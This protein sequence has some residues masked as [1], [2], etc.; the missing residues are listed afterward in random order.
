MRNSRSS[1]GTW[2]SSDPLNVGVSGTVRMPHLHAGQTQVV[3][4]RN[5]ED[6]KLNNKKGTTPSL[7]PSLV[8]SRDIPAQPL[9]D[10]LSPEIQNINTHTF[11]GSGSA[12]HVRK[13]TPS[14]SPRVMAATQGRQPRPARRQVL[15]V[16]AQDG[17][18]TVSVAEGHHLGL[19][20][21]TLYVKSECPFTKGLVDIFV[22]FFRPVVVSHSPF[23]FS[24]WAQAVSGV[25]LLRFSSGAALPPPAQ[26]GF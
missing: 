17:P 20:S 24:L 11:S 19:S 9:D 3:S 7:S 16:D 12:V 6:E 25:L 15:R 18:W 10:T 5:H 23:H 26:L 21:Y 2:T 13:T 1:N 8:N 4:T 22:P 14:L